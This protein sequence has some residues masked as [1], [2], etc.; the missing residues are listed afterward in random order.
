MNEE[1][2]PI[3]FTDL[4]KSVPVKQGPETIALVEHL[5]ALVREALAAA[6]YHGKQASVTLKLTFKPNAG[7]QMDIFPDVSINPPKATPSPV[8]MFADDEGRLFNED[9]AQRQIPKTAHFRTVPKEK[10]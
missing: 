6:R 7:N 9:P 10:S 4:T 8:P 5:D 1:P 3:G 2:T